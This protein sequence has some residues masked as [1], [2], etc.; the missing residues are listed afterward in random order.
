MKN[1]SIKQISVYGFLSFIGIIILSGIVMVYFANKYENIN[2]KNHIFKKSYNHMLEY[3][4]YTERLLTT[5]N[6]RK[7]KTLWIESKN[8]FKNTMD[9][10]TFSNTTLNKSILEFYSIINSESDKI[11]KQLN[12][13]LFKEE[14]VMEKSILRRLGE[15]LNSNE[16]SDYYLAITDLK[17]SIDYLKQ[18]EG[19]LLEEI[20]ELTTKQTI[21]LEKK[22]NQSKSTLSITIILI[23]LFGIILMFYLLKSITK[24]EKDLLETRDDLKDTLEET[25]N[26]LN[27]SMESIMI[28]KDKV[29]IDVNEETLKTFGYNN[30]D[31]LIGKPTSIFIAPD[32]IELTSEKQSQ[33]VVEPYSANCIKKDGT[34][35]PSL[36]KA[37]NFT[38]KHGE[39]IR[40]SAIIDL[41]DIKAKD[42]LLF[43]QSKMATM[44]EMIENIAHQ[45]RQPLSV[46][47]AA[48]TGIQVQREFGVS[49]EKDENHALIKINDS[50]QHLSQTIDDFRDFF[51]V[52]KKKEK[53]E[54]SDAFNRAEDLLS[55]KFKNRDIVVIKD[56]ISLS[57]FGY[58]NELIQAFMNI[59]TNAKDAL[60]E[61]NIDDKIIFFSLKQ[62]K[63]NAIATIKDNAGGIPENILPN[64]FNEHFTTKGDKDGT[65]I[66]L[67][68]TKMIIEKIEGTIKVDN[69]SFSHKGKEYTGACFVITIP[70][71]DKK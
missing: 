26:I 59:L 58:E 52:N 31:E 17:H 48:S 46:I 63:N 18:Y 35:L 37:Y 21:A 32:S 30:K 60:E 66:G 40:V 50:V 68:M 15:G 62:D 6:L 22:I 71:S 69:E 61:E 43:K 45:W 53:F 2:K 34:I 38:N 4:Y 42:D 12:N 28:A 51:K 11:I 19:F 33:D 23:V 14:N 20:K 44:G 13:K 16:T 55:S 9:T 67:Y 39:T 56:T 47:S 65:G 24:V 36:I 64:V 29:C 7:E 1:S 25:T 10:L 57:F 49:N 3:K 5:H 8:Q 54:I 41:T 70:L 27:A